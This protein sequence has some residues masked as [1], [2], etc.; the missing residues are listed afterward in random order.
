MKLTKSTMLLALL[1][2]V[3]LSA[4]ATASASASPVWKFNGTE[5]S[6]KESV[7][8]G[9]TSSKLTLLGV[10]VECKHFLYNSTVVNKSGKGEGEVTEVLLSECTSSSSSCPLEKTPEATA[11]PW[12]GHLTTVGGKEYVVIGEAVKGKEIDVNVTFTGK[13]CALSGVHAVKGTAGGA[14]ENTA[15]TATFNSSSF[16]ETGTA[17]KV[18]TSAVEWEGVYTMEAFG[19]HSLQGVEG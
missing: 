3:A 13:S 11:L 15:H 19:A 12:P 6:G 8:G 2:A 5:L 10:A 4:T 14:I 7:V 1:V 18:G 17:L 16:K 9:T